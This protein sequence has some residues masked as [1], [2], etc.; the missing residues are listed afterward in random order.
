MIFVL[1]YSA[2]SGEVGLTHTSS[3]T[4]TLIIVQE[5]LTITAFNNEQQQLDA[6]ANR[7]RDL[8]TQS[9]S[10]GLV[11]HYESVDSR[12]SEMRSSPPVLETPVCRLIPPVDD[13][14]IALPTVM[15]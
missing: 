9:N 1:G 5:N 14:Y 12:L 2:G 11:A 6:R 13:R 4:R 8:F 15:D 7:V 10:C 3:P